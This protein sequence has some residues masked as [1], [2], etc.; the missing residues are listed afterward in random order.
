MGRLPTRVKERWSCYR[1]ALPLLSRCVQ[2]AVNLCFDSDLATE[3]ACAIGTRL[4]VQCE[5]AEQA[6]PTH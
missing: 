1:N 4:H 3:S 2:D 5:G 6:S